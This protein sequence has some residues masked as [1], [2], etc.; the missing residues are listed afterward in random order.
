MKNYLEY[1]RIRVRSQRA[2][3]INKRFADFCRKINHSYPVFSRAETLRIV[4]AYTAWD[5]REFINGKGWK[6]NT[7]VS[8]AMKNQGLDYEKILSRLNKA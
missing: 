7:V 3:Q 8:K 4:K 6:F 1:A 5:P 2:H